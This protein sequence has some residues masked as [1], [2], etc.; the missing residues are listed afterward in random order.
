[1]FIVTKPG[2]RDP[3][4]T[5]TFGSALPKYTPMGAASSTAAAVAASG[6]FIGFLARAVVSAADAKTFHETLE[7]HGSINGDEGELPY[8]VG[9][10]VSLVEIDEAEISGTDY[11][12]VASTGAIANNTAIGT[13]LTFVAGK[14]AV[15]QTGEIPH[16]VLTA[17]LGAD[18]DDFIIRVHRI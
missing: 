4:G 9:D 3:V 14:F 18:G 16:F 1:M 17:Q 2:K 8:T 12:K 5:L 11:L 13:P 7:L 15:A 6:N 10:Y